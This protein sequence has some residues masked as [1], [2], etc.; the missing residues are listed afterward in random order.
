MPQPMLSDVHIARAISTA[1]IRYSN[2]DYIAERVCPVINVAKET[3]KY[4]IFT[5][6][7][8]FRDQAKDDRRPG[9]RAPRGGYTLSTADYSC[10]EIA[11]AT[12]LPDRIRDNADE[13]LRPYEDAASYSMQMILLRRERRVAAA[14]FTSSTWNGGS[15]WSGTAWSDFTGSDPAYDVSVAKETLRTATGQTKFKLLMGAYVMSILKLHPDGLDRFKHV[16]TGVMTPAMVAQWLDVDEIIVGG[17]VYNSA[18]EGASVTMA[19][20][21]GKHA[22]LMYVPANPSISEP[23]A[24]YMFRYNG[25]RTKRYREEAEEQD[26]VE[27]ATSVD[28]QRTATDCGYYFPSVVS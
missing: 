6:G 28:V 14:L 24:A 7:D 21:W 20:I 5:K 12:P 9:T 3:D 27:C 16:Q 10:K 22:L 13:P 2:P 17:S 25:V 1:A 18:D 11:H 4:F 26:V 8:W 23:S 15:D 19:D